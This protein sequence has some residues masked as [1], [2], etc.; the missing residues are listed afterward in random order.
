MSACLHLAFPCAGD[1]IKTLA[2]K[3]LHL[4][5]LRFVDDS[6]AAERAG[7]AKHALSIFARR[8]SLSIPLRLHSLVGL[9]VDRLV[10]CLL[11][12]DAV[13]VPK[14]QHGSPLP[15]LGV[16]VEVQL[17][18]VTF[19]PEAAKVEKWKQQ[20]VT[21][22]KEMRLTAGEASKLAG[23]CEACVDHACHSRMLSALLR[24]TWL[25]SPTRFQK[26]CPRNAC[27]HIQAKNAQMQ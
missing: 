8:V 13:S 21:A 24:S 18:G 17:S 5:V 1:L 25:R 12:Q 22:L 6:F 27:S 2:R 3:L 19:I 23:L 14:L 4:P 10:R 7:A 15:I 11:G 9:H 16:S 26:H 20:I